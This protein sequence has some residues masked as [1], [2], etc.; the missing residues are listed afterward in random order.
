[1][2]A[3]P[4]ELRTLIVA[5]V[6]GL[7]GVKRLS[8]CSSA[9]R[10]AAAPRLFRKVRVTSSHTHALLAR[11]ARFLPRHGHLVRA[12]ELDLSFAPHAGHRGFVDYTDPSGTAH[13]VLANALAAVVRGLPNVVDLSFVLHDSDVPAAVY[14]P[15]FTAF[16]SLRRWTSLSIALSPSNANTVQPLVVAL[17]LCAG[18]RVSSLS[19]HTPHSIQALSHVIR[20]GPFPK[21]LRLEI[22][23]A[24]KKSPAAVVVLDET[25]Q[26]VAVRVECSEHDAPIFASAF[27]QL[28]SQCLSSPA[29]SGLGGLERAE[30][31][32]RPMEAV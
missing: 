7:D 24:N 8:Q 30:S 17:L 31:A 23:T 10:D 32:F 6:D 18:P 21:L 9:W 26:G 19:V 28:Q 22:T 11:M 1:M 13:R 15:L 14:Q 12:L 20:H 25:I 29:T 27:P 16:T 3:L 2:L 5:E 4:L